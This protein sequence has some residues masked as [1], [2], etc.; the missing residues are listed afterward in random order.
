MHHRRR[1]ALFC[2]LA[3]ALALAVAL[4]QRPSTPAGAAQETA[5]HEPSRAVARMLD[6]VSSRRIRRSIEKLVS[7]GTRH[8]LSS[9]DDPNRGVGAARDWIFQTLQRYA[10]SSGGRMTVEKQ[11]FVQEPGPRVPEPTVITNVVATL[12]GTQPASADRMYVVSGHY[13]SRCTDVLN[14]TC[15]APGADDDASGVAAVM[16]AARVMS[17]REFDA[18]IVFMA[19]AGEEQGLFGSTHFAE[20]AK[21]RGLDIEGMFT[22]DIVGSSTADTGARHPFEVRL[23]SEGVPTNETPQQ[24]AVRQAI[25][26]ESDA[27]SRQLARFVKEVG[28]NDATG[29]KV[30]LI[31]RRDR[32]LRGG[33]QIPFLERGYSAARFTEPNENFAHQH[34]DVRVEDGVQFGDLTRFV[35][36]AYVARV[37]RVNVAALAGL[38]LAPA[39]PK[40]AKVLTARLTNDTDLTWKANTEPDLAGYEVVWRDTQEPVWTHSRRVGNVTSFTVPSLSKDN[41]Q[42]G[43]RAVDRD[44]NRS[45]V[46]FPAPQS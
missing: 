11:S 39:R 45:P 24:A 21:Q 28:Q 41:F 31:S 32:F 3:L 22:N 2:G 35:D 29:M 12:R 27:P 18:T 1:S 9:Q 34:Q 17:K 15:D 16:E 36:F 8:T 6:D 10:A 38:A 37:T 14:T 5:G 42:F 19:V 20:N 40:E 44:G 43:V 25:G 4:T 7:F 30:R 33:D 26:G 13:D 46:S 23:F